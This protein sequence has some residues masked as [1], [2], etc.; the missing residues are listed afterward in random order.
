MDQA[1]NSNAPA[2]APP[3][4]RKTVN[5]LFLPKGSVRALTVLSLSGCFWI[6]AWTD[7]HIPEYM[8]TSLSA[9]LAYYFAYRKKTAK[10]TQSNRP[11]GPPGKTPLFLP[12]GL[13]RTLLILG[14]SSSLIALYLTQQLLDPKFI[15]FFSMLVGFIA[16]YLF[17]KCIR[18]TVS[19]FFLNL[20]EHVK[21]LLVLCFA[22]SLSAG[23][24]LQHPIVYDHEEIFTAFI[25]FYFGSRT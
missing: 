20:T 18:L 17:N 6:L 13:V 16:G 2:T 8:M 19:S 4:P 3:P 9:V 5:P 24:L 22:F 10:T 21:A 7:Q 14:F 15:E 25:G 12:K 11:A 23:L 1:L